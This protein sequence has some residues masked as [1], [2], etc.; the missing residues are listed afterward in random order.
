MEN[1]IYNETPSNYIKIFSEKL[2]NNFDYSQINLT[3]HYHKYIAYFYLNKKILFEESEIELTSDKLN[4]LFKF[5]KRNFLKKYIFKDT[6]KLESIIKLYENK[7]YFKVYNILKKYCEDDIA[8]KVREELYHPEVFSK[9][10]LILLYISS[11]KIK[12]D[13]YFLSELLKERLEEALQ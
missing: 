3:L 13:L 9:Q 7:E 1:L 5:R 4:K 11:M 12:K 6:V 8:L 2:L 10:F